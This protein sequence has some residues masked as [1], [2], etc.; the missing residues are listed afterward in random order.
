MHIGTAEVG[1]DAP[2]WLYF[3]FHGRVG[4]RVAKDMPGAAQLDT[5]FRPFRSEAPIAAQLTVVDEPLVAPMESHAEHDFRFTDHSV[6]VLRFGVSVDVRPDGVWLH[7]RREM[8]T[9]VLP[10]LDWLTAQQDAAMIHAATFALGDAGIAMPAWGGVGKTSTIAKL[11]RN[12]EVSFFGDDWAWVTAQGGLLGYAKPMFIKPHHRPIYPHLFESKRKV[13]V[14]SR[15]SQPVA[16]LTTLVHPMITRYPRLASLAR[17]WSPEYILKQPEEALPGVRIGRTAPLRLFA[18][19][20]RYDGEALSVQ[21]CDERWM[22]TRLLG[23]F[24]YEMSRDSRELVEA[25]SAVG[26]LRLDETFGRKAEVLASAVSGLP[27]YHLRVPASASADEASD[28][29]VQE[30]YRLTEAA[31]AR[32][33]VA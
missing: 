7:G 5:M 13:M 26:L 33:V 31:G 9:F 27:L 18:F 14:P 16:E 23:N 2:N 29:I 15:L 17:R 1:P 30:L 24:Y 25:L 11:V 8:L 22:V 21:P 20:E 6:T 32:Y 28:M 10:L 4:L 12:P 3:D 19:V